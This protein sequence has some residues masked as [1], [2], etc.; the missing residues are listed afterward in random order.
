MGKKRWWRKNQNNNILSQSSRI[1]LNKTDKMI[2]MDFFLV[3]VCSFLPAF[4]NL[5]WFVQNFSFSKMEHCF[6]FL[7]CFLFIYYL[8]HSTFHSCLV[9]IV[10]NTKKITNLKIAFNCDNLSDWNS[11]DVL[12]IRY[13]CFCVDIFVECIFV[14]VSIFFACFPWHTYFTP[15]LNESHQ[16]CTANICYSK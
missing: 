7:L 8:F 9:F 4:C 10:Y 3:I 12:K 5:N 16:I 1:R 6:A 11:S 14:V 2:A 13:E 15:F